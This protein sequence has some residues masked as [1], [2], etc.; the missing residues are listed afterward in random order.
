MDTEYPVYQVDSV[1]VSKH[2]N[3]V[4]SVTEDH[5]L[6]VSFWNVCCRYMQK[7][8]TFYKLLAK[9]SDLYYGGGCTSQNSPLGLKYQYTSGSQSQ[10]LVTEGSTV[11]QTRARHRRQ[12]LSDWEDS[13]HFNTLVG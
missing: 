11:S 12:M 1:E 5:Q 7:I 10:R 3:T 8:H 6:K 2:R 4:S 9:I 13:I